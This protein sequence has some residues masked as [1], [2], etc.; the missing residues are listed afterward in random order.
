LLKQGQ[1]KHKISHEG[2]LVSQRSRF[3]FVA[4]LF[5]KEEHIMGVLIKCINRAW[6]ISLM[7]L[8]LL[9]V[10]GC[11]TVAT[12]KKDTAPQGKSDTA[13][14]TIADATGD[15]GVPN[16]FGHYLRG[17]GYIRMTL[18]FDSLV[19]KDEKG[20]GKG[21]AESWEWL[22]EEK[23]WRFTLR[24]G[25]KW[26]DGKPFTARDV[27]FSF[28]Y[29][30]KHPYPYISTNQVTKAVALSDREVKLFLSEPYAP[31]LD[32][33]AASI[34]ILPEHLWKEAADPKAFAGPASLIGTGPYKLLEY[35]R[36]HGTYRFAAVPDHYLGD[37]K[38]KEI[39]FVK[40]TWEMSLAA[41]KR[42]EVDVTQIPPD[43]AESL[44]KDGF[45]IVSNEGDWVAK[46]LMN[47]RQPPLDQVEVRQALAY[48]ID[49]NALVQTTLRGHGLPGSPGLAPPNSPW[50]NPEVTRWY[51]YDRQKAVELLQKAGYKLEGNRWTKDGQPLKLELLA[52]SGAMGMT[53]APSERQGEF[54]KNQLTQA[55]IEVDLRVMDPK[56]VDSRQAAW[57]FQLSLTG[58]GGLGCDP[59]AFSRLYTRDI[60][61]GARWKG[62]PEF[63][64]AIR[65]AQQEMNPEIRKNWVWKVQELGARDL[66]DLP[67]Y[68]PRSYW[69]SN[70]KVRLW[71]TFQG[72]GNGAPIPQN[73]LIFVQGK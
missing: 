63:Q 73:K 57:Q 29:Y 60:F 58:T 31:F 70:D 23:A 55:G 12:D 3:F 72:V 40:L 51:P 36:E 16:P 22:P 6:L 44:G 10:V 45:R 21:L 38:I 11:G 25:V 19:W 42:G 32:Y 17:P 69:A 35:S 50:A 13:I 39:R 56:T 41:L 67:L 37:A 59:E 53:G 1:E 28:E 47:H 48:L 43:M 52:A 18:I 68:Y 2:L 61:F 30:A 66:P 8:M 49:R 14:L 46:M 20:Y 15:W 7:A 4:F 54:I 27:V 9:L 64:E 62:S 26:H 71:Y 65:Q 34:P 33:I 24:S 5:V